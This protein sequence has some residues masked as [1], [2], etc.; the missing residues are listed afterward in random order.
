MDKYEYNLKLEEIDKLVDQGDY[1]AAAN[2]ADTIE[3]RRVRNVRTLCLISEIYEAAGNL[4]KSKEML[5]R[6]YRKSPV[7]RTVL[8]RL[9]E[10]TTRLGQFD[11][12]LEYYSEYVQTAPHDNN[13]YILKYMIYKGRGSS[14]EELIGILE[15]Y[16]GLEYTE[17]WAYELACEYQQAGQIQKCLA[18]CDDLVLWFHSGKYVK[19]A[20]ELKKRY[21]ALTPK[22]Q[23]IYEVCLQDDAQ[24]EY[25]TDPD[26]EGT[27]I[28]DTQEADDEVVAENILAETEKEIAGEI[29]ARKAEMEKEKESVPKQPK[30]PA[31]GNFAARKWRKPEEP[32]EPE[33][34]RPEIPEPENPV[35]LNVELAKSM[36]KVVSG[37]AR[38]PEPN[39]DD[40]PAVVEE[41]LH[42]IQ[43]T[44]VS[45][46]P[47]RTAGKL[48]IDD[49]LLAMGEKGKQAAR[50]ARLQREAA[51]SSSGVSADEQSAVAIE[52]EAV[53]EA[54]IAAAA[55]PEAAKMS[56]TAA[57][58]ELE[59]AKMSGTAADAEPGAAKEPETAASMEPEAAEESEIA[60]AMEP[61]TV[62]K[63]EIDADTE[64]GA[65]KEP[66]PVTAVG[67]EPAAVM[68]PEAAKRTDDGALYEAA[69]MADAAE[70][71]PI[72]PAGSRSITAAAARELTQ[73]QLEA[74]RYSSNPEKFLKNRTELPSYAAAED[75]SMTRR[76]VNT[77]EEL[78][79]AARK[80]MMASKTIRI[81]AEE[82][83]RIYAQGTDNWQNNAGEAARNETAA[84]EDISDTKQTI[85]QDVRPEQP[86]DQAVREETDQSAI[87]MEPEKNGFSHEEDDGAAGKEPESNDGVQNLDG[88][89]GERYQD[90]EYLDDPLTIEPHLRGLFKGFTEI[91]GIEDQIA[92]AILQALSKGE[93]RTSRTGNILIFG[94]HGSGKTTLATSLARAIAQEKGR[95]VAKMARI[96]GADLNRKDIA[97]T[98]AKI[99]GGMLIV[100][101]A[102]DLDDKTVE[103]LT[104]AMEFRT[105]GLI[106]ILEDEQ[107]YVHDLLMKHP[108]FTMKFTA[109][110]YLPE[111][112]ADELCIFAQQHANE[113]DYMISEEGFE[114]IR[115]K[116][117]AMADTETPMSVGDTLALVDKAIRHS[118]KFMRKMSMGKKRYDPNDYVLLFAKDFK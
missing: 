108:R 52:P 13:R 91:E 31:L 49:I 38:N 65:G 61:E 97:A 77:R 75:L 36:R 80:E 44:P 62:K 11:E 35:D 48:S 73:E 50:E 56:G 83:A 21:A 110:I 10:V 12:A 20:L 9:V 118:N 107:R 66:E 43:Q 6:A 18:T 24:K 1:R 26:E 117:A 23:Q 98:I 70:A 84:A 14:P 95:K 45:R 7:G 72:L 90:E 106:V 30:K 100:E 15:E 63:P 99:A 71:T 25:L 17:R 47:V 60:L 104:T 89:S 40:I 88:Q 46:E 55:E 34:V 79:A 41:R 92:N 4:T 5:E 85:T 103:Q 81:P 111:Y 16:L 68:K 28:Q 58:A 22:Q 57:D 93:D 113:L 39:E 87:G 101:E 3:W 96:Y 67:A 102:G 19:K 54:E 94:P 116:I 105:D 86:A 112:T 114:S 78:E 69:D 115:Q 32:Q 51:E 2:L 76:I 74:L 33:P 29:A 27:V 64:T 42:K 59:T 53:K 8:Y 109:Q 37:V 82:V